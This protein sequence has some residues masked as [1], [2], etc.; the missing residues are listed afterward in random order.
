MHSIR[1][2]AELHAISCCVCPSKKWIDK[3]HP[4]F[5]QGYAIGLSWQG[6]VCIQITGRCD[7]SSGNSTSTGASSCESCLRRTGQSEKKIRGQMHFYS[8]R[9]QFL[10]HECCRE[11]F[12]W[13][14]VDS[15]PHGYFIFAPMLISFCHADLCAGRPYKQVPENSFCNVR[16]GKFG[17]HHRHQQAENSTVTTVN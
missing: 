7:A 13:L 1:W 14:C 12:R 9:E 3:R 15:P 2:G 6:Q 16:T 11:S 4:S 8:R 17:A 5:E 10:F